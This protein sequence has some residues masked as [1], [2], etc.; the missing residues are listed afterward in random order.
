MSLFNLRKRRLLDNDDPNKFIP[1]TFHF[2]N[3]QTNDE[4][5]FTVDLGIR[6]MLLSRST[7]VCVSELYTDMRN[8]INIRA[9]TRHVKT[10]KYSGS[11]DPD[12]DDDS[13]IRNHRPGFKDNVETMF[14]PNYQV[15]ASYSQPSQ[16]TTVNFPDCKVASLQE[17]CTILTYMLDQLYI[18]FV[19]NDVTCSM[20][21]MADSDEE[22]IE[23]D[24]RVAR[25]LGVCRL[26]GSAPVLM[27]TMYGNELEWSSSG[28]GDDTRIKLKRKTPKGYLKIILPHNKSFPA[29]NFISSMSPQAL[30][31]GSDLIQRVFTG[32]KITETLAI[33]PIDPKKD[34]LNYDPYSADWKKVKTSF[35]NVFTLHLQDSTGRPFRNLPLSFVLQFRTRRLI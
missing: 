6:S 20:E 11:E 13:K 34:K 31:V 21:F 8:I 25:V 28:S 32:T 10:L 24:L 9:N 33:V 29:W 30:F 15:E 14:E 3:V 26:D 2:S 23:F 4:G 22:S 19:V 5:D 18:R 35:T 12:V 27:Q 17:L 16:E 1:S 7:E